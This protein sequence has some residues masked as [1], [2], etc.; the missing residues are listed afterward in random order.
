M[1]AFVEAESAINTGNPEE[2]VVCFKFTG[3]GGTFQNNVTF[4][5]IGD[6]YIEYMSKHNNQLYTLAGSGREFTLPCIPKD[7]M[8]TPVVQLQSSGNDFFD[9]RLETGKE[10][11]Y[12][13]IAIDKATKPENLEKLFETF[14]V[15]LT[16]QSDQN[17]HVRSAIEVIVCY[18]GLVPE[19]HGRDKEIHA[20]YVNR[21]KKE[22]AKT[23]IGFSIGVWNDP[24][25]SAAKII[26]MLELARRIP[27]ES[28]HIRTAN[29][30]LNQYGYTRETLSKDRRLYI[31]HEKD[32]ICAMWQSDVMSA[33]YIPDGN[34][35]SK[36][37][38][39]IGIIDDH[40]RRDMH[41][42][43][44]FDSTLPRLEDTLRKAVIKHGACDSLY[45]DN[46]KIFVSEQFKLICARLGIRIKFATPFNC[47]GKGKIERYWQTV[48]NSF[49][50][51]VRKQPVKSLSELND[52][53]F[54]WKKAEYD[55]KIHSSIGMTPKERWDMSLNAGTKLKFFSPVELDEICSCP[56]QPACFFVLFDGE[57]A[58]D[59]A[60]LDRICEESNLVT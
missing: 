23:P 60:F 59:R 32:R 36:M 34:N 6:P 37:A 24:E 19:W 20:R 8:G 21:E 5:L 46:G 4:R 31:K 44:Y 2:G 53:Y 57:A 22:M 50:P 1:G 52:L 14:R 55:D 15:E 25:R 7:F 11:N 42:E 35:G 12:Q 27:E 3:E 10:N 18:E 47:A 56:L 30:I 26:T 28:V 13:I 51:E 48:Q 33:F 17:E 29:R 38:Y 54:A 9:L 45:V 49:L 40:S 16:A 41:S 39:L 58:E 43:F